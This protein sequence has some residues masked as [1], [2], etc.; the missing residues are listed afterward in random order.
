M[1]GHWS[2]RA[3]PVDQVFWESTV[4]GL[5]DCD[6]HRMAATAAVGICGTDNG[7]RKE[8]QGKWNEMRLVKHKG[9]TKV[10]DER[11]R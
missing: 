4:C 5:D 6:R 7:S 10:T 2:V 9:V 8:G 3:W 1:F 11:K